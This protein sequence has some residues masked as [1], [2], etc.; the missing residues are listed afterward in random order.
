MRPSVILA[1]GFLAL[2]A[3]ARSQAQVPTSHDLTLTSAAGVYYGHHVKVT[4]TVLPA[5]AGLAVTIEQKR[6]GVWTT[7]ATATTDAAGAY[8]ASFGAWSI[9]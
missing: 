2:L 9:L 7:V 3:P 1:C 4:G 5:D 6:A 8:A